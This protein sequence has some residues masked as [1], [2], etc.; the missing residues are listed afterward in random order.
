VVAAFRIS[1]WDTPFWINVNRRD[2][3]YAI[4]GQR[5]VQYWSLHPLNCWAEHL[6]FHNVRDPDEARELLARP[7][8]ADIDVPAGTLDVS[9]ETAQDHGLEPAALIDENWAACQRWAA[10]IEAPA[11]LVPS[12]ALPG[13]VNLVVFG[14]RVRSRWGVD[15]VDPAID[16][17]TEPVA[18]LAEVM[19][20]LLRAVRWRGE[21]H[22]GYEAWLHGDPSPEPPLVR[23]ERW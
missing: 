4:A 21:P 20:D 6:R 10:G 14:E 8:V 19:P 2:S 11:F 5:I 17:P 16:T 7:W 9:F 3:R 18:D 12:A 15:P 13:T 1:S 22:A 23:L